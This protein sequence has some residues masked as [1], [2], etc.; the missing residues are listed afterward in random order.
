MIL[1]I[2]T[3]FSATYNVPKLSKIL[4][5]G[6]DAIVCVIHSWPPFY[7]DL[8]NACSFAHHFTEQH[9]LK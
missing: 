5:S 2:C 8:G 6:N 1:L 4:I 7:I 3:K 9:L